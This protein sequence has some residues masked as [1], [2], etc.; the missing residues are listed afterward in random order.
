MGAI[1]CLD[2]S[3]G[4][5]SARI[6]CEHYVVAAVIGI[7]IRSPVHSALSLFYFP[8]PSRRTYILHT[9]RAARGI[10]IINSASMNDEP[11]P[12]D[13]PAAMDF[14]VNALTST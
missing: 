13:R 7:Y 11:Q 1:Q 3:T 12:V 10:F 9:M 6:V 5:H 2:T 4:I 8:V 14:S